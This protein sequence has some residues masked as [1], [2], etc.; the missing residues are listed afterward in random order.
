[1]N[2]IFT[3]YASP[4]LSRDINKIVSIILPERIYL[5]SVILQKKEIQSIFVIQNIYYRD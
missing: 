5:L 4:A 2:K 3:E 1:M